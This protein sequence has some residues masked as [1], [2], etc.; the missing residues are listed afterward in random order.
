MITLAY[1]IIER[2]PG[3]LWK[4]Q[5]SEEVEGVGS[6]IF[7]VKFPLTPRDDYYILCTSRVFFTCKMEVIIVFSP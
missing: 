4:P 6:E 2:K 7:R 1:K 5:V 3:L